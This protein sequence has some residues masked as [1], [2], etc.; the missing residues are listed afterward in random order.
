[1]RRYMGNAWLSVRETA[2]L[3]HLTVEATELLLRNGGLSVV[4]LNVRR[5]G[6]FLGCEHRPYASKAQVEQLAL[7]FDA[8]DAAFSAWL[9]Q[10]YDH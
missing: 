8:L 1:V 6:R 7:R 2:G 3:L 4:W 10:E 5:P 9:P